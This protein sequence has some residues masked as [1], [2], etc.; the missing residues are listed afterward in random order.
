VAASLYS[1][2]NSLFLSIN[3]DNAGIPGIV[4][5]SFTINGALQQQPGASILSALSVLNP[6]LVAGTDYWFV[7]APGTSNTWGNVQNNS[8]GAK[9]D[10]ALTFY[11]GTSWPIVN[12]NNLFAAFRIDSSPA[13]PV[14]EPSSFALWSLGGVGFAFRTYFRRK[15]MGKSE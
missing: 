3:S 1:G 7:Y 9:G 2:T 8:I 10:H 4:L 12:H 13:S 14:P 5:E 6:S 15:R 11:G